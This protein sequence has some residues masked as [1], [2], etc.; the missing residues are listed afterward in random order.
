MNRLFK[1]LIGGVGSVLAIMPG[2]TDFVLG[3]EY[4]KR[5]NWEAIG[6]DWRAVGNDIRSAINA[7]ESR[8]LATSRQGS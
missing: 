7:E 2:D 8:I 3:R 4:M 1:N 6:G 5:S